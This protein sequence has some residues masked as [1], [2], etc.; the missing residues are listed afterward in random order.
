M[1][2]ISCITYF[3]SDLAF[4]PCFKILIGLILTSLCSPKRYAHFSC[5]VLRSLNSHY[6]R[7]LS[8]VGGL[9]IQK[10]CRTRI[11]YRM[12]LLK[13]G[14]YHTGE[15]VEVKNILGKEPT[16]PSEVGIRIYR[17]RHY[18]SR[19][20]EVP[21]LNHTESMEQQSHKIYACRIHV[22]SKMFLLNREDLLN[23]D[24]VLGISSFHAENRHTYPLNY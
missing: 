13:Q 21:R 14:E 5:P 2:D 9:T 11:L 12:L 16:K 7:I 1:V 8:P 10:F 20:M 4:L 3:T 24:R 18:I 6:A 19:I 22:L 15:N 23:F 17:Y